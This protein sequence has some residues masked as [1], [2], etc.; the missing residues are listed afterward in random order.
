MPSNAIFQPDLFQFLRQLKRHND[1]EWF[2]KNKE[3][4]QRVVIEP[5]MEF[6]RGFAPHLRPQLRR[7]T[8]WENRVCAQ[9]AAESHTTAT[10]IESLAPVRPCL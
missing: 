9:R 8:A 4:Y 10:R 3:R 2:A 1:R 7:G 5:A 6:I